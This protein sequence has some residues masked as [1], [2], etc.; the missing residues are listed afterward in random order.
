MKQLFIIILCI[1]T[2]STVYSQDRIFTY[3]YQSG[4]LNQ[5]QKELEIWNTLRTGREQYY[6]RFDNRS[7]FEIGLGGKLQTAF[8]LNISTATKAIGDVDAMSLSTSYDFSFSN[9]WK[10]KLLDPVANPVGLAL[11]AEYGIGTSEYELEG[12]IILD[13][14]IDKL[15]IATNLIYEMELEPEPE[16]DGTDWEKEHKAEI[17]LGFAYQISPSMNITVENLYRNVIED[18]EWEHSAYYAGPG[19]SYVYKNFWANFTVMPQIVSFKEQNNSH[20][21]LEEFEKLQCR[22]I[23]S[24]AFN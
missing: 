6:S 4:V 1:L 9:E 3:T 2:V 8:Y 7:E 10:L 22:L 11:Y 20:L 12:K 13:K 17:S 24:Y 21:D 5:G 14:K 23:F 18:G 19:F 15:T 16:F